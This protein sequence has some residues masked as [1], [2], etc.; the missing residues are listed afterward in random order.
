MEGTTAI[1]SLEQMMTKKLPQTDS[2]S[3]LAS[4]WQTHDLTDFSDELE[5]VPEP[6]FERRTEEPVTIHLPVSEAEAVKRLAQTKGMRLTAL[7]QEWVHEK[8]QHA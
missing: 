3:E 8:L 2:I 4:F 7:I 6:V 5:E 1:Q